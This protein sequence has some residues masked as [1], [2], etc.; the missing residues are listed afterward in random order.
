[1]T[2]PRAVRQR[3]QGRGTERGRRPRSGASRLR[4]VVCARLSILEV[5]RHVR[6]VTKGLVSGGAA[7]AQ[8]NPVT[9]LVADTVC[10]D[11]R[12]A[13]AHP[14][15]AADTLRRV[16]H[17]PDGWLRARARGLVPYFDPSLP[18][19]RQG[20]IPPHAPR[21]RALGPGWSFPRGPRPRRGGGR[22]GRPRRGSRRPRGPSGAR[23]SAPPAAC[24]ACGSRSPF[25][26]SVFSRVRH[27]RKASSP[28]ARTGQ[29]VY[30]A[31]VGTVSP[32]RQSS[33]SPRL[34]TTM[35]WWASLALPSTTY[36]P[37]GRTV[38]LREVRFT[39][40]SS[41]H[42]Q[43][44]GASSRRVTRNYRATPAASI[45]PMEEVPARRLPARRGHRLLWLVFLQTAP[46][47]QR[48]IGSSSSR[49]KRSGSHT[50]TPARDQN[51][52]DRSR[53][54]PRGGSDSSA[55]PDGASNACSSPQYT[56]GAEA[57]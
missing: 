43:L 11:D 29:R 9:D 41:M 28:N 52:T 42:L 44:P 57:F 38:I 17:Q 14:Q 33:D 50:A 37:F 40:R 10:A 53:Y 6:A 20:R 31:G 54:V 19:A 39:T 15:G 24:T 23:R 51:R 32:S 56:K 34:S 5:R 21:A 26:R 16:L 2:G 12:D 45:A 46:M 8:G 36:G 30:F 55:S 22:S 47:P 27:R 7:A 48:D 13:S 18:G 1:M 3:R 4:S 35:W 49:R 25:R